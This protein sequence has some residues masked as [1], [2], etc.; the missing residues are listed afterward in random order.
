MDH[1]NGG[2]GPNHMSFVFVEFFTGSGA[3][4]VKVTFTLPGKNQQD[5]V[6]PG[7]TQFSWI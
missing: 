5:K 6:K 4:T 1:C 3:V 2:T 7:F